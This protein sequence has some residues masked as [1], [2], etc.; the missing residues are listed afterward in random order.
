MSSIDGQKSWLQQP[1]G[2]LAEEANG[3]WDPRLP[4]PGKRLSSNSHKVVMWTNYGLEQRDVQSLNPEVVTSYLRPPA[5]LE[6]ALG[7]NQQPLWPPETGLLTGWRPLGLQHPHL[8]TRSCSQKPP[9]LLPVHTRLQEEILP[10]HLRFLLPPHDMDNGEHLDL[11]LSHDP[12][13]MEDV[14]I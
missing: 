7:P 4:G 11:P 12:D 6:K 3:H 14:L 5:R 2:H 13:G 8:V 10:L 1:Q 9:L